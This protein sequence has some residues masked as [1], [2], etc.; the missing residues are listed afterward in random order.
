MKSRLIVSISVALTLTVLSIN[1]QVFQKGDRT[2]EIEFVQEPPCPI[3]I[4]TKS[5]T[6]DPD[7][8]TDK[9][10]IMLQIENR[11]NVGIRAYSMVSGGNRYPTVHTWIFTTAPLE[12]GK[13]VQRGVWP[14]RQEHYYF[15]FD[16]ILYAD[17]TVCGVNNHRR[18]IQIEGYLQARKSALSRLQELVV[19]PTLSTRLI[20]ELD[21]SAAGGFFSSDKAGPPNEETSKR[22]PQ[23][24]WEHVIAYLRSIKPRDKTITALAD[25]LETEIPRDGEEVKT[26]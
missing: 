1:A 20:E 16:Y 17:G 23:R 18:A 4:I 5:V 7:P 9:E 14:N 21:S 25:K 24:A 26:N 8:N 10:H 6:L 19:D 13:T 15:F 2:L 3:T 12:S 11:S 22:M